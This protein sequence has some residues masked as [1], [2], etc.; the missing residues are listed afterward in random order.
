MSRHAGAWKIKHVIA[1][2]AAAI[3]LCGAAAVPAIVSHAGNHPAV[4]SR[5]EGSSAATKHFWKHPEPDP[6]PTGP[7]KENNWG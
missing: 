1:S 7:P 6:T 4:V 2:G 3:V 5:I